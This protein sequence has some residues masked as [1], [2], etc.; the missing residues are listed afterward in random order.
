MEKSFKDIASCNF[1]CEKDDE[2]I[3]KGKGVRFVL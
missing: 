3:F 1:Q 2:S